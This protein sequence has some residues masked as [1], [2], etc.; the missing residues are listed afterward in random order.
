MGAPGPVGRLTGFLTSTATTRVRPCENFWRTCV[1]SLPPFAAA[2]ARV[3]VESVS[4]LV[5]RSLVLFRH[6]ACCPWSAPARQPS[7]FIR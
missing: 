2:P 5:G 4:G 6:V 3:V 1:A 7:L